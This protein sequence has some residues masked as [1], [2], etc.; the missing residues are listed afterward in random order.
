M[1][2]YT[3]NVPAER[4]RQIRSVAKQLL[5]TQ[6]RYNRDFANY[7]RLAKIA[8]WTNNFKRLENRIQHHH[9]PQL[10]KLHQKLLTF[11]YPVKNMTNLQTLIRGVENS[12]RN[13]NRVTA[14]KRV[15]SLA[16]RETGRL[17]FR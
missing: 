5:A 16:L 7:E 17:R 6:T 11:G 3:F 13:N 2:K 12:I 1:P 9:S 10:R 15:G 4:K 8:S 14:M